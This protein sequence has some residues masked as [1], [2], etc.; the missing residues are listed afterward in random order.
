MTYLYAKSHIHL[1][2]LI[3]YMEKFYLPV[4]VSWCKC[5]SHTSITELGKILYILSNVATYAINCNPRG[6]VYPN[7][8][9]TSWIL[10]TCGYLARP[11]PH[12]A[13]LSLDVWQVESLCWQFLML[14]ST[15]AVATMHLLENPVFA[16]VNVS[17]KTVN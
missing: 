2:Y 14:A 17:V 10:Y 8:C 12:L 16:N 5:Y 6:A 3:Y 9:W 1:V 13:Q 11:S 7:L 15:T 4:S